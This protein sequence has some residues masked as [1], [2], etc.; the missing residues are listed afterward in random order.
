MQTLRFAKSWRSLLEMRNFYQ[1]L[2]E[3]SDVREDLFMYTEMTPYSARKSRLIQV[4]L[5]VTSWKQVTNR[6]LALDLS[7]RRQRR[8]P[9]AIHWTPLSLA[10]RILRDDNLLIAVFNKDALS[11]NFSNRQLNRAVNYIYGPHGIVTQGVV[12]VLALVIKAL[13]N[14]TWKLKLQDSLINPRGVPRFINPHER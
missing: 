9:Q 4:D 3:I 6:F 5:P 13:T 10:L 1:Y 12:Y 7:S 11:L 2:L 8:H 14:S